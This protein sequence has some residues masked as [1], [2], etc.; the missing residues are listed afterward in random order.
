M[1][2]NVEIECSPE[3][4]RRFRWQVSSQKVVAPANNA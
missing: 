3:E 2:V 4:V 1:K